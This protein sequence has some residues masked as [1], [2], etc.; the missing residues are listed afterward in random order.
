MISDITIGQYFPGKSFIHKMD[1]RMKM[2]LTVFVIVALFICKNFYSL[3]AV[4]VFTVVIVLLSKIS[5]K[6]IFKSVKPLGIIIIIT[7]LLNLFYGQGEPLVTLFGRLKITEEGIYTAIFMAVRIIL[8]V[9]VGSMLTY[10]TTPT[11]LT[12]AIERLFSPLKVFKLDIHTVAMTMTIALRF[13]PTL[14]EEIDKIMAAQK[15]RGADMETGGLIHR[16]KA[17]IPV[18]IPLFISSFRRANELA[19]AMDCRCYKGGKGR[20]KMKQVKMTGRDFGAAA[21][22]AV[23]FGALIYINTLAAAVI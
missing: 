22:V 2:I 21:V 18:L 12:D 15:S 9:I 14:I 3:A 16:A 8:L 7:S 6:T 17:L 4:T 19:Y 10:T 1:A 11:D 23:V 20:T 5:L 13:I